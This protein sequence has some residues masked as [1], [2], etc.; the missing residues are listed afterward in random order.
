MNVDILINNA[1]ITIEGNSTTADGFE[2]GWGVNHLGHFAL[3]QWMHEKGIF[4]MQGSPLVVSVSSHAMFFGA[5]DSSLL[6]DKLGEGDLRG[7]KTVGC[8]ESK[9]ALCF[10]PVE[11]E[12]CTR[13]SSNLLTRY[14]N[15][16][17]YARSKLSN[18]LFA[19]ELPRRFKE[20]S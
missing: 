17:S 14:F 15:F 12:Q 7:E 2:L 3:T 10:P 11:S 8:I 19:A 16:G 5:F 4:N 6:N 18:V 1:G 13:L 20:F 9:S